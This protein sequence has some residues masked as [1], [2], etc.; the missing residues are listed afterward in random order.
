MGRSIDHLEHAFLGDEPSQAAAA[1][2]VL[3]EVE[4]NAG[5]LLSRRWNS[6]SFWWH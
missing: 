4:S 3:R 2:Q 1:S 5:P 6:R